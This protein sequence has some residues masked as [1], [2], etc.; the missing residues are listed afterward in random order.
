MFKRY[1]LDLSLTVTTVYEK[2]VPEFEM[3]QVDGC[4]PATLPPLSTALEDHI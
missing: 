3:D 2:L 1:D 4:N